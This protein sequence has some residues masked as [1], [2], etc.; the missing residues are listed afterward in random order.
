MKFKD[1]AQKGYFTIINLFNSKKKIICFCMDF[2]AK[3]QV[4]KLC[5]NSSY[6]MGENK[7]LY[8]FRNVYEFKNVSI[9]KGPR[10]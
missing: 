3:K 8:S 5:K 9:A 10:V 7:K 1:I 6:N 4:Q 2:N